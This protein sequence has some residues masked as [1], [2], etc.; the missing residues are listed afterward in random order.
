[1]FISIVVLESIPVYWL[2]HVD[3]E[4]ASWSTWVELF[5]LE[6]EVGFLCKILTY[7]ILFCL[8]SNCSSCCWPVFRGRSLF[9]FGFSSSTTHMALMWLI[10]K[11]KVWLHILSTANGMKQEYSWHRSRS[12]IFSLKTEKSWKLRSEP[13]DVISHAGVAGS[14]GSWILIHGRVSISLEKSWEESYKHNCTKLSSNSAAMKTHVDGKAM[15]LQK[16]GSRACENNM[17]IPK[18][19]CFL[20]EMSVLCPERHMCLVLENNVQ[21]L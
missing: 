8:V 16:E 6:K 3:K 4:I 1:M 12:W 20:L 7:L 21:E 14:G 11:R 15:L 18:A 9:K 10:C 2:R 13:T 19:L 5:C 17:W